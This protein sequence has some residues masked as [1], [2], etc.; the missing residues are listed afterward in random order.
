MKRAMSFLLVASLVFFI[1]CDDTTG[2]ND[3]G[4]DNVVTDAVLVNS[5]GMDMEIADTADGVVTVSRAKR[6]M[7]YPAQFMCVASLN[8]MEVT[9]KHLLRMT[10]I[11]M[12]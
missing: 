8:P 7:T 3:S 12:H 9:S 5:W 4:D 10:E 1:G 11:S 6:T 2:S